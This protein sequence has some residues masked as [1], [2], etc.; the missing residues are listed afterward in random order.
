[1]YMY[2]YM[3]MYMVY[4]RHVDLSVQYIYRQPSAR[5][6]VYRSGFF[7]NVGLS[8]DRTNLRHI[9]LYVYMATF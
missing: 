5:R 7:I 6:P 4:L 8:V 1:M 3:Y 2:M 9:G